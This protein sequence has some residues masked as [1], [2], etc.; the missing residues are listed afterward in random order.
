MDQQAEL[1][2][3]LEQAGVTINGPNP[4]DPQIKN[5]EM[6]NRIYAQGS[7]GLGEAYMDGWWECED[8][9]EFFNRVV[10]AELGSKLRVTPNLIWQIVQAKFLNMQTISRSRRVAKMHYNETDAYAASLDNRMTGSCG[11][12]P[13][14]VANVDEAQEAK[15]DMVCRKVQLK[16]GELVWDIGCGW[17]AF[18]GFAAEKYG[19][20]CVGVTVSP[21]PAAYGRNRYKD[22]PSELQVKD[23][24]E[25]DGKV[26]KNGS[27]GK[28]EPV[29]NQH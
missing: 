13:E 7:L 3:L 26:D 27:M 10:G 21:D 29:G 8:L 25:F 20:R 9:A 1:A 2:P 12:W 24:R 19:A 4:W 18:M 28:F 14:G 6:W 23:D 11:Y 15:L 22:L 17:G 16:P 5:P